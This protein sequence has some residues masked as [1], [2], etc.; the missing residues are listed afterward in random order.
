MKT[1]LVSIIATCFKPKG[2]S[3]GE[4]TKIRKRMF[5]LPL[6]CIFYTFL[7]DDDPL[8]LKHV[9]II[10]TCIVFILC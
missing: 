4:S 1:I 6:F 7:P 8:G 3:S 9:A 10:K 5:Y 2:P